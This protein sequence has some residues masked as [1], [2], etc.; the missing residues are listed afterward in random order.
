MLEASPS[1]LTYVD[2]AGNWR[3]IQSQQARKS[4]PGE[5]P[6]IDIAPFVKT[7]TSAE[8][9]AAVVQQVYD[10]CTRVGFLYVKGHGLSQN[11]M[12]SLFEEGVKFFDLPEVSCERQEV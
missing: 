3:P 7:E 11:D 2:Y 4:G 8:A 5:I 9:K 12:D 6:I 10:A 1:N